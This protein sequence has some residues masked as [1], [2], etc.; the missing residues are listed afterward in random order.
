MAI[1]R[2]LANAPRVLLA[3]EPTGNLDTAT[4]ADINALFRR[5]AQQGKSLLIVTHDVQLAATAHRIIELKDGEVHAD[6]LAE[7]SAA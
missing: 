5:L 7:R 2:A 3:D 4:A 6:H 1:A